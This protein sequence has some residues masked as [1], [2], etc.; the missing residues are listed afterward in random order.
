LDSVLLEPDMGT[1]MVFIGLDFNND[2]LER[3]KSFWIVHVV[4]SPGFV[5]ISA[6]FGFYYFIGSL[7]FDS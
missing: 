6:L 7:G 2:F 1:S 4:L 3:H 5:A